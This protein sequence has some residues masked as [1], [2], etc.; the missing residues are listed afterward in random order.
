MGQEGR[1][2]RASSYA[3]FPKKHRR[4]ARQIAKAILPGRQKTAV[5]REK[6][7]PA[8]LETELQEPARQPSIERNRKVNYN[9][10]KHAECCLYMLAELPP[11]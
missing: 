5:L 6:F 8:R 3:G 7:A 2:T 4:G 11:P 9:R 10:Q 1:H